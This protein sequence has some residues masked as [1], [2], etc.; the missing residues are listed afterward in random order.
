M[1]SHLAFFCDTVVDFKANLASLD[2]AKSTYALASFLSFKIDYCEGVL[3]V[4]TRA[5]LS[6][7]CL[8]PNL[9]G[10]SALTQTVCTP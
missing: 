2:A 10:L 8:L 7:Y 3:L 9:K 1:I 4:L 5:T 6:S